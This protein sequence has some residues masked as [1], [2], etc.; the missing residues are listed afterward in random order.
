MQPK[1]NQERWHACTRVGRGFAV[2]PAGPSSEE[3]E[4]LLRFSSDRK[5]PPLRGGVLR[6]ELFS[7]F[8]RIV[9]RQPPSVQPRRSK[10]LRL[11]FSSYPPPPPPRLG[12]LRL[13]PVRRTLLPHSF[14]FFFYFFLLEKVWNPISRNQIKFPCFAPSSLLLSLRFLPTELEKEEPT[15]NNRQM[16]EGRRFF[17]PAG[18][19]VPTLASL[20]RRERGRLREERHALVYKYRSDLRRVGNEPMRR[21]SSN[22]IYW[23]QRKALEGPDSRRD[24]NE[25]SS[26]QFVSLVLLE[27]RRIS[28]SRLEE[29]QPPLLPRA[30]SSV[31]ANSFFS[32][33][34]SVLFPELRGIISRSVRFAFSRNPF[35]YQP[36]LR[37]IM[38]SRKR[39]LKIRLSGGFSCR[40][41]NC[42]LRLLAAQFQVYVQ[43]GLKKKREK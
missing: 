32:F 10:L 22:G 21:T 1:N 16:K 17:T 19:P 12:L 5:L 31:E 13:V 26:S 23:R 38:I 9:F 7:L 14:S 24:Q 36:F 41:F 28:F 27:R 29:N 39:D 33:S 20:P 25:R 15:R 11:F 30:F 3:V 35:L 6:R 40:F 8:T 18:L 34:V 4:A 2:W 42:L 43:V 37:M